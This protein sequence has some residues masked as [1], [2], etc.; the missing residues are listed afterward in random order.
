MS[1]MLMNIYNNSQPVTFFSFLFFISIQK[2]K[3]FSSLLLLLLLLFSFI[4]HFLLSWTECKI[5]YIRSKY[6]EEETWRGSISAVRTNAESKRVHR[7]RASNTSTSS[8]EE[9]GERKWDYAMSYSRLVINV[10]FFFKF[11]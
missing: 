8:K 4:F 1:P 5:L 9:Q 11:V 10:L 7:N 3:S 2:Y 6:K